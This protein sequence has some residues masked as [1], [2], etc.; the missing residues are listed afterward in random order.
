MAIR[1]S[2]PLRF[3]QAQSISASQTSPQGVVGG[4]KGLVDLFLSMGVSAVPSGGAPVLDVYLHTSADGIT[5]QDIAHVQF[6]NSVVTKFVQIA[7][8]TQGQ[9]N[10]IAS[11]F[12]SLPANLVV[13]GPW[14]QYLGVSWIFTGGGSS[15][16]YVLTVQ[17][18]AK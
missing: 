12:Q 18:Y 3:I 1:D 11:T 8:E 10:L 9:Q 7:G 15:G 17:G 14:G 4:L 6:T 16:S 13:H 5:Y 2:L